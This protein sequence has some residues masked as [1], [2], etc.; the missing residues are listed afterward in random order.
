M[1]TTSPARS[2]APDRASRITEGDC[3]L[4]AF[5]ALLQAETDLAQYPYADRAVRGVLFYGAAATEAAGD[6]VAREDLSDELARALSTGPGIV[7]FDGAFDERHGLRA[8]TELFTAMIAEQRA[9]GSGGGDHFAAPGANDRIWNALQKHAL[10]DPASFAR[11]YANDVLALVATAWLGPM[12]QVTSAIN[13][14][15]P[16]GT[17]QSPHRDYHLGFM[18]PETAQ[19]FPRHMHLLSPALTLQGAVAQVDMPV[20]SGP[21]L[22]LPYSQRYEPGYVAFTLPE[23]RDY[24]EAN[25]VQLPLRAGDAVFFNPALFHAAGSN[26]SAG[27]R[28][29][30]NLLQISSAFG[31]AMDAVDRSAILRS[32]YPQLQALDAAGETRAVANLVAASAEG[33][34]FPSN[35]DRDQPLDGMHGETQAELTFRALASGLAPEAYATELAALDERHRP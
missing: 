11:Y 3:D 2:G 4:D 15:N 7:V 14:V 12:Y 26:R 6:P 20:S 1:S 31:R 35:L 16:G 10:R 34:A 9:T 21:T 29:M 19:R 22:Y 5:A 8:S 25:H 32:V 13:V 30:A 33:Y 17:A 23:F 27:I 18:E 28:R 24:F